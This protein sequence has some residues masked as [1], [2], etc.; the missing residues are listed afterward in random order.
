MPTLPEVVQNAQ[1]DVGRP[2]ATKTAG[3]KGATSIPICF[4]FA[5]AQIVNGVAV[6]ICGDQ[7]SKLL[8]ATGRWVFGDCVP[9]A[10]GGK[11]LPLANTFSGIRL[12]NALLDLNREIH[13]KH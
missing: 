6:Q 8:A 1:R 3:T 11:H 12:W 7:S 13:E 5:V 2:F 10:T 9:K 4:F